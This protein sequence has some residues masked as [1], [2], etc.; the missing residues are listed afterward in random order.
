M[1]LGQDCHDRA[2]KGYGRGSFYGCKNASRTLVAQG[3]SVSLFLYRLQQLAAVVARA[4]GF[5]ECCCAQYMGDH[6]L[7]P[8]F[9]S[10]YKLHRPRGKRHE[11]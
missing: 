6:R 10:A 9:E 7:E 8:R 2:R 11:T 3:I 1:N 4:R 5:E